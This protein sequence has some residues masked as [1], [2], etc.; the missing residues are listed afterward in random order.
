MSDATAAGGAARAPEPG[1][2]PDEPPTVLTPPPASAVWTLER[3]EPAAPVVPVPPAAGSPRR[4]RRWWRVLRAVLLVILLPVIA[5]GIGLLIAYIAHLVRHS[6]SSSALTTPA[7]SA[8]SSPSPSPSQSPSASPSP[9]VAVPADWITEVSPPAGLSYRHPAGWIRRTSSPEVFRFEPAS[10]GSQNPG[11]E[12]VGA[13]FEASTDPANALRT[14]AARAYSSQPRFVG[15]AVSPVAG[16]HPEEQQQIVTYNRSGV[17]VRVV[18]HSF[19]SQ[20]HTVV[21]IGR[22]L[23]SQPARAALLE[24]QVEASLT[25][26]N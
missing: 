10:I 17:A 12:G 5:L 18:L 23:N 22:S 7:P 21:V 26:S 25:F 4:P 24:A 1:A 6:G 11:V 15:G 16:Q 19:R 3:G 2:S 13:G 8:S 20:G 14:V 9:R